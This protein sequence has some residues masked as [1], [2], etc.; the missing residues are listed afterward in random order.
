[1]VEVG[2]DSTEVGFAVLGLGL[3]KTKIEVDSVRNRGSGGEDGAAC[4]EGMRHGFREP[5]G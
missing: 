1:M 4:G 3:G 5:H 2:V